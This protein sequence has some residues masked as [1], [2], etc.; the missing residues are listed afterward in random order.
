VTRASGPCVHRRQLRQSDSQYSQAQAGGPCHSEVFT[1]DRRQRR[2]S[3][4]CSIKDARMARSVANDQPAW[5]SQMVM[6]PP[7]ALQLC[8][9]L[10]LA[11]KFCTASVQSGQVIFS[12][13]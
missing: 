12:A 13:E 5:A 9:N 3:L 11:K 6:F 2:A 8:S 7:Q 1:K 10:P 4:I